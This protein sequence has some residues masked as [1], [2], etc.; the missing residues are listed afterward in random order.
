MKKI[1]LFDVG[2]VIKYPFNL[3]GFYEL[4]NIEESY[5]SFK[6]YFDKTC[7]LVESGKINDEDF[8]N[9]II[10]E[11]NLRIDYYEIID[12][13]NKSNGI[14]NIEALNLLKRIRDNG[15]KVYIL[16][17]LKKLDYDNF[18]R[19]VSNIYYD[20]FYKSYEIGLTKPDKK[21]YEYVV[22][23]IEVNPN[24]VLFFDDREENINN[25]KELG[26]DARLVNVYNIVEY[27]KDN[28][29]F[30]II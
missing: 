25:A 20:K 26:I 2:N 8:F 21:I 24:D 14:Y 28:N 3:K 6:S 23:D 29:Y 10:R 12:L 19:D 4:L 17:N 5:D 27:F 11:F 9:G 22:K 1:F 16:S 18:I 30:D 13:Y 7:N 15:N